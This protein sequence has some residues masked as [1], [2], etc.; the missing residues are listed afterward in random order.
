MK[1]SGLV[2]LACA[3]AFTV[4]CGGDTTDDRTVLDRD[5]P[6]I[7]ASGTSGAGA[8]DDDAFGRRSDQEFV[9]EMMAS[10]T[11]EVQLGQLA[12]QRANSAEVRQFA[13]RM[14]QDHTKAGEQLKQIASRQ[15]IT[16]AAAADDDHRELM[17]RLSSAKGS[18]FDREYMQAMV[19]SHE[20]VLDELESRAGDRTRSAAVNP[21]TQEREAAGV[22]TTAPAGQAGTNAIAMSVEQWASQQAPIVREHL[23]RAKAIHEKLDTRDTTSRR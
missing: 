8:D 15:G 2:S 9:R 7:G 3:A 19:D 21:T 4:A 20:D 11:A 12:S 5:E 1:A 23:E 14:V 22:A 10:G 17:E 6:T 18:E 16:T 13:E